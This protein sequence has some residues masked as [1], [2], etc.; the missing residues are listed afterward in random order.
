MS[1]AVTNAL[2]ATEQIR[3]AASRRGMASNERATLERDLA[4]IERA[5]GARRP[6]D[7][8]HGDP[9]A[10]PLETPNDLAG[11]GGFPGSSQGGGPA[12]RPT[13]PPA[14]APGPAAARPAGTEV[15]GERTRRALDA[16]DFPS[17]VAGLIQGTFQA[18][19]DATAHQVR[20][21][22]QLVADLAKTVDEF[23]R[24]NVGD[25]Q[26]REWLA[27]RHP[28]ELML[29]V[30]A[31]G[32][33]AAPQVVPREGAE[34]SPDWLAE[35]GLEGEQLTPEL[36]AGPVMQAGRRTL[37]EERMRTLAN[38]VLL[39]I[40]RIVVDDGQ[41]RARLQFHARAREQVTTAVQANSGVQANGIAA[42]QN[43]M[44]SQISTMVSTVD[45]NAQADIA[46]KAD[47]VGEV[48]VKFRTETFN[49]ER[50]ADAQSIASIQRHALA[51]APAGP[52]GGSSPPTAP[53]DGGE[54][55]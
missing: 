24:D 33:N 45:V 29:L 44:S 30:P 15:F 50:F 34:E 38:M 41:L 2:A 3:R 4:R 43:D 14:S 40:N 22:A 21:Y 6:S 8:G 31:P 18:I 28:R 36:V 54:P 20:E 27:N 7:I 53:T 35:Y 10:V 55:T 52:A 23:T 46:I 11:P 19:V 25:A 26:A 1:D 47:L 17:F 49:L 48:S 13:A 12:P 39:G 51:R 16:V 37:G 32:S 42:R 9:Y 5:L